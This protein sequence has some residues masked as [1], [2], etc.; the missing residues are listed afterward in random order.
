MKIKNIKQIKREKTRFPLPKKRRN[1]KEDR[2]RL[3]AQVR[4][5]AYKNCIE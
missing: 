4:K 3:S 2:R 5:L 1:E